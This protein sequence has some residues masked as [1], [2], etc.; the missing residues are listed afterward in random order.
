MKI[1]PDGVF[2]GLFGFFI[3]IFLAVVCIW[4]YIKYKIMDGDLKK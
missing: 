1:N 4:I 2:S 3:W